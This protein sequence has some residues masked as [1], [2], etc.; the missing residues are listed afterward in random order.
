MIVGH[1]NLASNGPLQRKDYG[2]MQRTKKS[3]L[4]VAYCK[5]FF[6]YAPPCASRICHFFGQKRIDSFFF[7]QSYASTFAEEFPPFVG[8]GQKKTH[9]PQRVLKAEKGVAGSAFNCPGDKNG[10]ISLRKEKETAVLTSKKSIF[11]RTHDLCTRK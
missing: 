6:L 8:S 1:R 5:C 9:P 2:I 11:Y 3:C 7:F 4:R 10:T